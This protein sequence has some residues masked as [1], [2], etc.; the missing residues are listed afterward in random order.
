MF[1]FRNRWRSCRLQVSSIQNISVLQSRHSPAKLH[2]QTAKRDERFF[3]VYGLIIGYTLP[4]VHNTHHFTGTDRM[5]RDNAIR[6]GLYRKVMKYHP[7]QTYDVPFCKWF[8]LYL[9]V[10]FLRKLCCLETGQSVQIPLKYTVLQRL[11]KCRISKA[12]AG[13]PL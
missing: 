4:F 12:L 11:F 3:T 2:F 13:P 10:L 9:P 5:A 7:P 1:F 6:Y 8:I